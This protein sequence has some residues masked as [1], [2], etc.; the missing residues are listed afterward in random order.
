MATSFSGSGVASCLCAKSKELKG[1]GKE[2]IDISRR[3]SCIS[4]KSFIK[5]SLSNKPSSNIR[6]YSI[7]Q[8]NQ[9]TIRLMELD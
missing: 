7:V 6:Q 3:N 2:L 9:N 5:L 8:L 1:L 4:H